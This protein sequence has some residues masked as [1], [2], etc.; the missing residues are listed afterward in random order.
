MISELL[1]IALLA[2]GPDV[3]AL[4][5]ELD[6]VA[7]RIEVL[8][9]K[10]LS[11]ESVEGELNA[12]LVRSQELAEELEQASPAAPSTSPPADAARERAEELRDRA[13]TLRDEADRLSRKLALIEARIAAVLRS[14]IAPRLSV[15]PPEP[16]PS[17]ASLTNANVSA[18]PAPAAPALAPLVEQRAQMESRVQALEREAAE[19]D[20]AANALDKG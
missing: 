1:T 7:G 18:A 2:A 9:A 16:G 4:R 15:R 8:K 12:L 14:A 20:A 5:R 11:G 3:H 6:A 10:R 19:L 17:H 13:S